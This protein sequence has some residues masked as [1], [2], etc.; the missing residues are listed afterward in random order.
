[1]AKVKLRHGFKSE[2]EKA[3]LFWREELGLKPFEKLPAKEFAELLGISVFA[4]SDYTISDQFPFGLPQDVVRFLEN[5][6]VSAL[7]MKNRNGNSLI[8]YNS[9]HSPAR[10]ESSI[11]HEIA[12][13]L[14][15]HFALS[16]ESVQFS[17]WERTYNPVFEE[18]AT[19]F[20]SILQIPDPGLYK[21]LRNGVDRKEIAE[22]F[23]A[24]TDM[25]ILRYNMCGF[26]RRRLELA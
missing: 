17:I 20:G 26:R 10:Q 8:I 3:S 19:I 6:K 7:T 22:Y 24:S 5:S 23:G 1:M 9:I 11:M 4:M 15:N 25:V 2:A 14:L 12:H 21:H 16:K 18:E 13:N